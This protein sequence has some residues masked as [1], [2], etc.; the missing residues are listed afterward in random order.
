[1]QNFFLFTVIQY[2]KDHIFSRKHIYKKKAGLHYC[3]STYRGSGIAF[4]YKQQHR[5]PRR[6]YI[7]IRYARS[8]VHVYTHHRHLSVAMSWI[9]NYEIYQISI[10]Q[11]KAR[12]RRYFIMSVSH[13]T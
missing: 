13:R 10:D 4:R 5:S 12:L 1:M 11:N 8:P 3:R 6:T 9:K 7:S 2:V